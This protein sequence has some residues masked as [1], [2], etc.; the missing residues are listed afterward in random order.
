M[1]RVNTE[2]G[3]FVARV[4]GGQKEC[5]LV[6]LLFRTTLGKGETFSRSRTNLWATNLVDIQEQGGGKWKM[7]VL[8]GIQPREGKDKDLK[9]I[10]WGDGGVHQNITHAVH[11]DPISGMHCWHQK[12]RLEKAKLDD[13]YG[14]VF[15]D[16]EKSTEVYRRW[17]KKTRPAP[18]PEG[19]RRPLWLKR[20]LKPPKTILF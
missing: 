4:F 12:V 7:N 20:P 15:V 16:T 3:Y 9:K 18:G 17:L 10:F 8:S 1:V 13:N 19:L 2:I 11:P 5:V 14:D 6:L